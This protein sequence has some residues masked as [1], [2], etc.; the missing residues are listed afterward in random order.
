MA[1]SRLVYL[2]PTD[3]GTY[4]GARGIRGDDPRMVP[5][6]QSIVM[7]TGEARMPSPPT[8]PLTARAAFDPNG[9]GFALIV[10]FALLFVIHAR[11]SVATQ[12]AIGTR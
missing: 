12:A 10:L 8:Q 9:A 2:D 6:S 3:P 4:R 7:T 5:D 1:G 11:F